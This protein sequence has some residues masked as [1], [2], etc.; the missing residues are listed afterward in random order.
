MYKK[1]INSNTFFTENRK[2]TQTLTGNVLKFIAPH[3]Y[4]I[5]ISPVLGEYKAY[6]YPIEDSYDLP[7]TDNKSR[8]DI[9]GI[10][11][12][13]S[14]CGKLSF[15]HCNLKQL[16]DLQCGEVI[17]NAPYFVS[18]CIKLVFENIAKNIE[19]IKKGLGVSG[20]KIDRSKVK[21]DVCVIRGNCYYDTG[22]SI[23]SLYL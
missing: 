5:Q 11:L 15:N 19:K 14:K 3:I 9:D 20:V 13:E 2:I 22:Y 8:M 21:I 23:S 1:Q 16:A 17:P 18:C 12:G 7:A 4:G 6:G 10:Y